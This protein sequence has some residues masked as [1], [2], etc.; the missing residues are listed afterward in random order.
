MT[1]KNRPVYIARDDEHAISSDYQQPI[2]KSGASKILIYGGIGRYSDVD[3]SAVIAQIDSAE[4]DGEKTV[5]VHI[6]SP[7]GSV[8]DGVAIYNALLQ[9][10]LRVRVVIDGLAAS[11]ASL[12]AMAGDDIEMAKN[13]RLMIHRARAAVFG[14]A[15]SMRK[16]ATVLQGI[17][18]DLIGVYADRSGQ[19]PDAVKKLVDAETWLTAAEAVK[20]GFAD[21]VVGAS[22]NAAAENTAH[23]DDD[24]ATA[25]AAD[26]RRIYVR[27]L[28]IET[29]NPLEDK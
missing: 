21:R 12:I 4:S 1:I 19:D 3:P 27:R 24:I 9:S 14:P 7:G 11:A 15:S 16:M 13:A 23:S 18:A 22:D 5:D 25:A 2:A 20:K 17:D 26:A 6:N 28:Q 10:P 29:L 8:F